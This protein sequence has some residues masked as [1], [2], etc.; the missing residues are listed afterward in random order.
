MVLYRQSDNWLWLALA[1]VW[2]MDGF[3]GVANIDIDR[4]TDEIMEK[5]ENN[6]DEN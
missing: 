5:Q 3:D 1:M 2:A 6:D 4:I